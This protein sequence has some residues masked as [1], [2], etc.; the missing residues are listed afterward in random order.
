[1][2]IDNPRDQTYIET[3]CRGCMCHEMAMVFGD[4]ANGCC[5]EC[6][7]PKNLKG[8]EYR[9]AEGAVVRS[10][11]TGEVTES[12]ASPRAVESPTPDSQRQT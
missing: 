11:A 9:I 6:G 8:W 1:M 10:Q 5:A 4:M 7:C 2:R 12:A 3:H